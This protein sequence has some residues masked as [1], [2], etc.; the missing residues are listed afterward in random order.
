M[1]YI[2]MT[3]IRKIGSE[4]IR[5]L[6]DDS[7][8]LFVAIRVPKTIE[9]HFKAFFDWYE[10]RNDRVEVARD[11]L[12]AEWHRDTGRFVYWFDLDDDVL[13]ATDIFDCGYLNGLIADL[14]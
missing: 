13:Y 8:T 3:E 12:F 14:G 6:S 9:L 4:D 11:I 2:E 7:E 5:K 10:S 1:N